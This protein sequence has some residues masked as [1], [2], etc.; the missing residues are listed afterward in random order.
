MISPITAG[1]AASLMGSLPAGGKFQRLADGAVRREIGEPPRKL[2]AVQD[3]MRA[4]D[5]PL[6]IR[7]AAKFPRLGDES[8]DIMRAHEAL[9]RPDFQRQLGRD[10]AALVDAG[11]AALVRRYGNV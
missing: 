7:L 1:G 3:A 8:K 4:D 2:D 9:T 11:K 5:W 10:P 6:A